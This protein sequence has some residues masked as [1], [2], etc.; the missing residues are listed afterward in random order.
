[1][2]LFVAQALV[3][4][5]VE[6]WWFLVPLPIPGVKLGLSNIITLVVIAFYGF[7]AAL[8]VVVVR[9]MLASLF[10]GGFLFSIS[11]GILSTLVM[12]LA[13]KKLSKVLSILGVSVLGSIAHNIGQL[14][15]ACIYMKDLSVMGYLPVLLISGIIMGCFVGLCGNFII[16]SLKKTGIFTSK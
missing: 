14:A 16:H 1:M 12:G 10:T 11:G 5:I 6:S 2:A 4:S 9:V 15:M 8:L 7:P 3:L 13:Y